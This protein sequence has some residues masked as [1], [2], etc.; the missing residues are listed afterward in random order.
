MDD[1][2]PVCVPIYEFGYSRIEKT[3]Q[4][5]CNT[6]ALI[7]TEQQPCKCSIQ[8]LPHSCGLLPVFK[9][10]MQVLIRNKSIYAGF[11]PSTLF[12]L[13]ISLL[14]LQ[15]SSSS[16]KMER[17][18]EV[19]REGKEGE[20]RMRWSCYLCKNLDTMGNAWKF[21]IRCE[22]CTHFKEQM[23]NMLCTLNA[24]EV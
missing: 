15:R 6:C 16:M 18:E 3:P 5:D 11:Q 21:Q 22:R 8:F 2:N 13:S 19:K 7:L 24:N 23:R 10:S 1:T 20:E 12:G 4:C 14:H 17:R 9:E